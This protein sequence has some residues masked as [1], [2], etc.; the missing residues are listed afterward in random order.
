MLL[1]VSVCGASVLVYLFNCSLRWLHW[2]AIMSSPL[3]EALRC[4]VLFNTSKCTE[5]LLYYC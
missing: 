5:F 3:L 4:E 1:F 2:H